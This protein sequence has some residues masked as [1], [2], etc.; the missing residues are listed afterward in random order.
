MAERADLDRQLKAPC[1]AREEGSLSTYVAAA[2]VLPVLAMLA[3]AGVALSGLATTAANVDDA[4]DA[5]VVAAEVQGG[6]T[7]TVVSSVQQ[8]LSRLG[9]DPNAAAIQGTP[10]PQPWGS[11]ISLTVTYPVSLSGFP[12]TLL[13]LAG[14]TVTVGGTTYA[15]SNRAP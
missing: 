11:P 12:W 5:A 13:G 9:I 4:R 14:R 7:P 8:T 10:S 2:I 1:A 15:T 6:V 3:A